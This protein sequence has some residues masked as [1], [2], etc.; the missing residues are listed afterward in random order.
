MVKS[1]WK[2]PYILLLIATC[3]WGGNFVVGKSLVTEVPPFLLALIRWSLA[4][5]VILPIWGPE[6]WRYRKTIMQKWRMVLFLSLT[7]VAGFNTL[8]YIAVQYTGSINASLMNAAT[9]IMIVVFSL[10]MLKERINWRVLPAILLSLVGVL[11]I[12]SRGS[13]TA[14]AGL[15]FNSGDLWM[16]TAIACWAL[17]SVGMKKFAGELP[18]HALFVATLVTALIVLIPCTILEWMV[19]E[20]EIEWSAGLAPGILFISIFPSLLSFTAWNAAIA[21]IGPSRCSGFLNLIPLFSAIFAT[22]FAGESIS[23]YHLIGALLIVTG[24]YFMNRRLSPSP[25]RMELTT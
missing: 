4:F 7:G 16:L 9:P 17:Y 8:T 24:V 20:P 12:I 22:L 25:K 1:M 2:S 21:M 6:C 15:S 18:V 23:A 19:R 14:I 5:I 10:F 11:W 3:F 13:W